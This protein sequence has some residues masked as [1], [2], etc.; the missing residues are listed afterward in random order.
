MSA[1]LFTESMLI[2]GLTKDQAIKLFLYR[3]SKFVTGAQFARVIR[4]LL[5]T[6]E[7]DWMIIETK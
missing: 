2:L 3:M 7:V 4:N 5:L 6:E 1:D